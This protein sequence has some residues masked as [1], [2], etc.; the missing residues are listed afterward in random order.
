MNPVSNVLRGLFERVAA[1]LQRVAQYD[2]IFCATLCDVV[3]QMRVARRVAG[4]PLPTQW[5]GGRRNTATLL[6]LKK[7]ISTHTHTYTYAYRGSIGRALHVLRPIRSV[8]S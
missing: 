2:R 1:H 3:Q 8:L 6:S 7:R 4:K 5:I